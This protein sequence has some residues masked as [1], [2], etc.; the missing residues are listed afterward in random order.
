MHPPVGSK[1]A[2]MIPN[3]EI[4]SNDI[5]EKKVNKLIASRYRFMGVIEFA[6]EIDRLRK[7]L[8]TSQD[9]DENNVRFHARIEK[10][11]SNHLIIIDEIHN[12]RLDSEATKKRVPPLLELVMKKTKNVKLVLM[13]ATPMF[14]DPREIVYITNL[15]MFNDKRAPIFIKSEYY[16]STQSSTTPVSLMHKYHRLTV[17]H[18]RLKDRHIRNHFRLVK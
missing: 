18:H 15:M 4:L 2:A 3:R 11:F 13:T 9:E 6:N 1:Y 8:G 16:T 14:N 5:I 17:G 12:L 7:E 10:E